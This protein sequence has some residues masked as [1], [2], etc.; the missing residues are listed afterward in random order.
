MPLRSYVLVVKHLTKEKETIDVRKNTQIG[1]R[2]LFD[3]EKNNVAV[4][5]A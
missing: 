1:C 3:L 2:Q 4:C 5:N